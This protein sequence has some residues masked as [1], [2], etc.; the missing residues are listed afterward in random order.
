MTGKPFKTPDADHPITIAPFKGRVIVRAGD[1]VIA[2]SMDALTL[3]EATYPPVFYLPR[4]D[5]NMAALTRSARQTHCPYKGQASYFDL[6]IGPEGLN[7][8]WSYETPHQAVS[9]IAGRLAFYA[10]KVS[11]ET[12]S[13]DGPDSN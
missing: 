4:E 10:N 2:D 6:P 3:K 9:A 5:V 12:I 1:A 8:V 11:I 13:L 7:A